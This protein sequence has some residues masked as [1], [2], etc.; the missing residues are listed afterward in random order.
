MMP[1][2]TL[3][4]MIA[5]L[6]FTGLPEGSDAE[7]EAYLRNWAQSHYHARSRRDRASIAGHAAE[8]FKYLRLGFTDLAAQSIPTVLRRLEAITR[9]EAE[10]ATWK[11]ENQEMAAM[12]DE[13]LSQAE[14]VEA[15]VAALSSA[16]LDMVLERV[17]Q[18]ADEEERAA[19]YRS[20]AERAS[21]ERRTSLIEAAAETARMQ[22]DPQA[23]CHATLTLLPL[24]EGPD[25][26]PALDIA[27][28]GAL[29]DLDEIPRRAW[30]SYVERLAPHLAP[31]T[32][33]ALV[34]QVGAMADE[35]REGAAKA[36]CFAILAPCVRPGNR[37]QVR[38]LAQLALQ[39]LE[40]DDQAYAKTYMRN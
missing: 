15:T 34:E 23:R 1:N 36:A 10:L 33:E 28:T 14:R 9:A 4:E 25:M 27:L 17:G 2:N 31:A 38:Y 22:G 29:N 3:P 35:G 16:P 13:F 11:A 18:V 7:N 19:V 37:E 20:L 40:P 21:G 24:L 8:V 5:A 39:D 30:P 12:I 6:A 32:A 26:A